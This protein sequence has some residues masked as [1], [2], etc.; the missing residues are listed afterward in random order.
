LVCKIKTS[1]EN[2][3]IVMLACQLVAFLASANAA[4]SIG[5]AAAG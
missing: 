1:V 2:E 5:A 4:C 3:V